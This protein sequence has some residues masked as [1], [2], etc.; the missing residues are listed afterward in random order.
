MPLP[1]ASTSNAATQVSAE[2][3]ADPI[4]VIVDLVAAAGSTLDRLSIEGVVRAIAGG[5][6]KRR[7]LAQALADQPGVLTDGRSP[8]P[9]VIGD[10]LLAL[11]AAGAANVAAPNLRRVR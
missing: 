10:L 2:V 11:R 1:T 4:C 8:A 3:L 7:R 6:V 9:R 5:R